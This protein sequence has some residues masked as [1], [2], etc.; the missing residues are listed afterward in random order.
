MLLCLGLERQPAAEVLPATV[1]V[2]ISAITLDN[3]WDAQRDHRRVRAAFVQLAKGRRTWPAPADFLAALP[4]SEQQRLESHPK[5]S[6]S[7]RVRAAAE[8]V[9]A[10]FGMPPPPKRE[11][12]QAEEQG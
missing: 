3:Q 12:P 4:Q 6:C 11:E 9:A 7:A 2:W 1:N 5:V 10:M 8:E